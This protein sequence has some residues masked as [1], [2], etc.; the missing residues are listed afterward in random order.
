[1]DIASSECGF[2]VGIAFLDT[3]EASRTVTVVPVDADL[4]KAA[5]AWLRHHDEREYSFVEA[6]S[7]MLMQSLG[8][9]ESLT[10]DGN[11]SA[12]GFVELRA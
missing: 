2:R 11:F 5:L 4:E 3:L 6:T 10:F 9:R 12:A 1:V 8:I 7:F